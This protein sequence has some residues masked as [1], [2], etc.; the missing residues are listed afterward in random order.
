MINGNFILLISALIFAMGYLYLGKKSNISEGFLQVA[1]T[2]QVEIDQRMSDGTMVGTKANPTRL[3]NQAASKF[4]YTVPGYIQS[5]LEP[6]AGSSEGFSASLRYSM[7]PEKYRGYQAGNPLQENFASL[8]TDPDRTQCGVT[9]PKYSQRAVRENYVQVPKQEYTDAES[10]LPDTGMDCAGGGGKHPINYTRYIYAPLTNRQQRGG[11]F[12]RGDLMIVPEMK[13]QWRTSAEANP[14]M[15]I[16]FG[17]LRM[18]AAPSQ[19]TQEQTMFAQAMSGGSV[20]LNAGFGEEAVQADMNS[21]MC[22][23]MP[24]SAPT[25]TGKLTPGGSVMWTQLA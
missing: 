12:I 13:T 25:Q 11:D 5:S 4:M 18:M 15:A 23:G 16:R 21:G 19:T 6:R 22:L 10:L 1:L 8:I 24:I 3:Y 7:A 17:A 20:K 9:A 2:P 14:L